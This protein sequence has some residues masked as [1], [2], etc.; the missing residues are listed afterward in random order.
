MSQN[1]ELGEQIKL[2]IP[3]IALL[4]VPFLSTTPIFVLPF[5]PPYINGRRLTP[6]V[7]RVFGFR[8]ICKKRAHHR[9]SNG[10]GRMSQ[11]LELG[12][13]IKLFI[14]FIALLP[15]PFPCRYNPP[16]SSSTSKGMV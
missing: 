12:E 10:L 9:N 4:P 14:P 3:F 7:G 1:L 5:L 2:F 6:D 8:F 11:N 15:V 16:S 13:Q